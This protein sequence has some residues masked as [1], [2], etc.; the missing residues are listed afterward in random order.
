MPHL[1][2]DFSKSFLVSVALVFQNKPTPTHKV[3]KQNVTVM[4]SNDPPRQL[5]HVSR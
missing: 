1:V 5:L 4:S 2:R 3:I